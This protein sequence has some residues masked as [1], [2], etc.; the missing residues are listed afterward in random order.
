MGTLHLWLAVVFTSALINGARASSPA[1]ESQTDGGKKK[2]GGGGNKKG[3]NA[4]PEAHLKKDAT[5][6]ADFFPYTIPGEVELIL[7]E[8]R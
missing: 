2:D 8:E 7:M 5:D 4:L 1:P 3:A 6:V